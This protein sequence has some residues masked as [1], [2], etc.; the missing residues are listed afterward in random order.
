VGSIRFAWDR[1][2][3]HAGRHVG[4]E[5]IRKISLALEEKIAAIFRYGR[6][7]CTRRIKSAPLETSFANCS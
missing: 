7:D 6:K 4:R 3:A 2:L 1:S 5:A